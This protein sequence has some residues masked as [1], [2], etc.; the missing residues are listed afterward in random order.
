MNEAQ[1]LLAIESLMKD[2]IEPE[3]RYKYFENDFAELQDDAEKY[4]RRNRDYPPLLKAYF[5]LLDLSFLSQDQDI[6]FD[7]KAFKL[8]QLKVKQEHLDYL[9]QFRRNNF[10][11]QRSLEKYFQALIDQHRKLLLV[12]VDLHYS[13]DSDVTILDFNRDIEKLLNRIHN[14]DRMFDDQVGY[15]YRLEQGGKTR[16][17]HCHLLVIYNGSLRSRD[18]YLGQEIGDLWKDEITDTKGEF[19]NCNQRKHKRLYEQ[20]NSLGI[21]LIERKDSR[22]IENAQRAISYLARPDKDDQYLRASLGG[23]RQLGK[24]Q[25]PSKRRTRSRIDSKKR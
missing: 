5:E 16:G 25:I 19:F 8:F 2:V 6:F 15:A 14:R 11:N 18:S 4:Y 23:M 13:S 3:Y 24:G 1:T 12:R 20:S 22:Q 21:G 17:Y 9:S 10:R 7:R